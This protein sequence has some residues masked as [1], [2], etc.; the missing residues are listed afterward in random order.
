MPS[1]SISLLYTR[2]A[3]R[4]IVDDE[5]S[6]RIIHHRGESKVSG[7]NGMK[8]SHGSPVEPREW[9][10]GMGRCQVLFPDGDP[11]AIDDSRLIIGAEPRVLRLF[12]FSFCP[13][14][15]VLGPWPVRI[16]SCVFAL[17]VPVSGREP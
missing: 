6:R 8:I 11:F 7:T 1:V 15:G 3:F 16:S 5:A 13:F 2:G 4:S 14:S 9:D 17:C 12:G 10:G